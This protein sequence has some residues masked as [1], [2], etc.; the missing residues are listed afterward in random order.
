MAVVVTVALATAAGACGADANNAG[1]RGA[2]I[3]GVNCAS[4]HGAALEGTDRGPSLLDRVYALDQLSDDEFHRA[5]R[6]GVEETRWDFGPMPA[7]GGLGDEQIDAVLGFVRAS[8][9][10]TATVT[11]P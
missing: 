4:C 2:A 8:Q 3:Y 10:A 1:D 9:G 5:V 6:N 11:S 7:N